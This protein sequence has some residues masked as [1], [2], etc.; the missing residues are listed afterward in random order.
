MQDA[1]KSADE[2]KKARIQDISVIHNKKLGK[3]KNMFLYTELY[4]LSTG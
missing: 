4:T 3:W 1:Q 2:L